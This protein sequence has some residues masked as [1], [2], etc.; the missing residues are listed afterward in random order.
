LKEEKFVEGEATVR[1][2][3]A[4]LEEMLYL[5]EQESDARQMQINHLLSL[6]N[7]FEH[8]AEV[9]A[10]RNTLQ[11][12]ERI[13]LQARLEAEAEKATVCMASTGRPRAGEQEL[14]LLSEFGGSKTGNVRRGHLSLSS[15]TCSRPGFS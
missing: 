14:G 13:H 5:K 8:A 1:G 15:L 12:Q 3:V 11:R 4:E 2:R 6:P 10:M 9:N 7:Q